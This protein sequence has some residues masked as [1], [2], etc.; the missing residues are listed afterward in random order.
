MKM[1]SGEPV[2]V[3]HC[4]FLPQIWKDTPIVPF[5]GNYLAEVL[6]ELGMLLTKAL[7]DIIK[8]TNSSKNMTKIYRFFAVN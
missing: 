8:S 4:M 6:Q 3:M 2:M 7:E 5:L 1:A